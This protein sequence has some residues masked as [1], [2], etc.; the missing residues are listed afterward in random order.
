MYFTKVKRLKELAFELSALSAEII[1]I[2]ADD[3]REQQ[4]NEEGLK[5]SPQGVPN[6]Y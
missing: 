4:Y 6:L 1:A 2:F 5:K 3:D